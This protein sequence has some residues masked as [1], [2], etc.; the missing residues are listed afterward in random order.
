MNDEKFKFTNDDCN[1]F[2]CRNNWNTSSNHYSFT[3]RSY[4]RSNACHWPCSDYFRFTIRHA[5]ICTLS[6]YWSYWYSSFF[7]NDVWVRCYFWSNWWIYNW[8]YTDNIF[9]WMVPRKNFVHSITG[10]Y[11]ECAWY[12]YY[13]DLWNR[14]VKIRCQ[15]V[16]DSGIFRRIRPV[17]YCWIDQSF[18]RRLDWCTRS[19]ALTIGKCIIYTFKKA[20]LI[21]VKACCK[22]TARLCLFR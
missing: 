14:M 8:I 2:I 12:V 6:Y 1:S 22:A 4:Y 18:P 3:A 13:T 19:P 5:I 17:C 10:I 11:C 7:T 9:H 21:Y 15:S 16:L 20:Q